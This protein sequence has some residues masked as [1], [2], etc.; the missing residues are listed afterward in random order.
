MFFSNLFMENKNIEIIG[1]GLSGLL[2]AYYI[3]KNTN[4]FNVT[5]FEKN[6][7]IHK[8]KN[9][10]FWLEKNK[11]FEFSELI[12]KNWNSWYFSTPNDFVV[13]KSNLF[14]YVLLKND[15]LLSF[16]LGELNRFNN[17]AIIYDR[18][19]KSDHNT[20]YVFDSRNVDRNNWKLSQIFVGYEIQTEY[21]NEDYVTLMGNMQYCP[22]LKFNFNY[23]LPIDDQSLFF[24]KTVFTNDDL[25]YELIEEQLKIEL[26]SKYSS[27]D[28]KKIEYGCIPMGYYNEKLNNIGI[29]IGVRAGHYRSSS[30]YSFQTINK[31]MKIY[32]NKICHGKSIKKKTIHLQNIIDDH[33]LKTFILNMDQFPDVLINMSRKIKP[34][35]FAKFMSSVNL[36]SLCSMIK[37][38]PKKIFLKSLMS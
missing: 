26:L 23:I 12:S 9:F 31:N 27:F 18:E 28:I 29:P 17:F 8:N 4:K 22:E 5:V 15:D 19:I 13:H 32:A 36:I 30:G 10:C 37:A 6:S 2:L 21:E 11:K 3:F 34:N 14:E 38:L 33:F 24:E 16:I 35:D 7:S 20:G 1:G 25:N